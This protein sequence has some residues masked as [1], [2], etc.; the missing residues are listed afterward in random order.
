MES[1]E[2]EI[3]DTAEKEFTLYWLHGEKQVVKGTSIED[4]FTRAGYG[5]G[6]I[7]AIDFYSNGNNTDYEYV[8]GNWKLINPIININ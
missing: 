3:V 6:A 8:N 5:A 2:K 1:V 7:R 4:A